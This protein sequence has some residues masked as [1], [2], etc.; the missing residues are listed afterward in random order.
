MQMP[1]KTARMAMPFAPHQGRA[2]TLNRK[3]GPAAQKP[4]SWVRSGKD[5]ASLPADSADEGDHR[6][7]IMQFPRQSIYGTFPMKARRGT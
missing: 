6:G 5:G 1:E 7:V 2:F 3:M 4:V